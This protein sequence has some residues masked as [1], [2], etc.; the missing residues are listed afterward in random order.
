MHVNGGHIFF[1]SSDWTIWT[2][3]SDFVNFTAEEK[4]LVFFLT[5][6]VDLNLQYV[7]S[8]MIS[9]QWYLINDIMSHCVCEQI[10]DFSVLNT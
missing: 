7:L 9:K 2:I 8:I 3:S 1:W 10:W 6:Y 5:I 4:M